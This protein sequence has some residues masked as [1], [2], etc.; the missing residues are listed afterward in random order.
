MKMTMII[1]GCI[2]VIMTIVIF[3]AFNGSVKSILDLVG[4]YIS[5]FAGPAA[6]AFILAMFTKKANDKGTAVGVI[7]GFVAWLDYCNKVPG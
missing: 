3:V 1:T 7:I 4:S 2:G 6:G 5:Y